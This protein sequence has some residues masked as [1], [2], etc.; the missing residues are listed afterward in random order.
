M[1]TRIYNIGFFRRILNAVCFRVLFIRRACFRPPKKIWL[2]NRFIFPAFPREHGTTED[3]L[4]C[5]IQDQYGLSIIQEK[6][7]TV[8]DIGANVGFFA[9]AARRFFPKATIHSYEPNPRILDYLEK[10]A[11]SGGFQFFPEAL[12]FQE[13]FVKMLDDSDSNQA[14]AQECSD[15]VIKKVPLSLALERLS[16]T[17]DLAKIDCEGGEWEIF[18]D[19]G[20]LKKI[21][22]V[23][24]EYHLLGSHKIDEVYQI[25]EN[26]SFEIEKLEPNNGYGILWGRN[27]NWA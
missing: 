23:R 4:G 25:L 20:S 5:F 15:G 13:G 6:I 8:L 10:N 12:G 2:G 26:N 7:K 24:M 14:Q 3:F 17:I 9:L 21:H 22:R 18:R 27:R 1:Q 16:G 11:R 19:S